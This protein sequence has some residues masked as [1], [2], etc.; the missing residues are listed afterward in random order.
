M[1]RSCTS[2]DR[3]D[4]RGSPTRRVTVSP[5]PLSRSHFRCARGFSSP[6]TCRP[7]TDAP[8]VT[9]GRNGARCSLERGL[10]CALHQDS[11]GN[12]AILRPSSHWH[13]QL[14]ILFS[15]RN[16]IC[17]SLFTHTKKNKIAY[18]FLSQAEQVF[19]TTGNVMDNRFKK[20]IIR[21]SFN[22]TL[23]F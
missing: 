16:R 22:Y 8:D 23:L 17:L 7:A 11:H 2:A 20:K 5:S 1:R 6:T 12:R 14:K 3:L 10:V 19:F 18:Y 9:T 15:L 13:T 21:K 4:E